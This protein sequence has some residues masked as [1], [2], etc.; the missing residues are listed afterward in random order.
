[1]VYPA[2]LPLMCTP[3][4]P[5]VNWTDAPADLTLILLMWRIWLTTNNA[6][7]WQ[8]RFNS[9][10]KGLNG[11]VRFA[12]R[13]NLVSACVPSHFKRSVRSYELGSE[14]SS[15]K[16]LPF[17]MAWE[18]HCSLSS[19][20]M[21]PLSP[22]WQLGALC[23]DTGSLPARCDYWYWLCQSSVANFRHSS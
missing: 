14:V 4:L 21:A 20:L 15:R 5:V 19:V 22:A 11:L 18:G 2:L 7:K 8:M 1:M 3:R 13:R 16:T 23:N 10:F 17:E 6:C 12:E 9:A